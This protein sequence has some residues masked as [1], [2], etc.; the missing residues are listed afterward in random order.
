MSYS[1]DDLKAVIAKV[2]G[3]VIILSITLATL[4]SHIDNSQCCELIDQMAYMALA[5]QWNVPPGL[6]AAAMKALDEQ[7]SR[8]DW[9]FSLKKRDD[10]VNHGFH[11]VPKER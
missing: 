4:R 3:E 10:Y 11:F 1:N 8:M 5:E 7:C 6:L 9:D 2:K